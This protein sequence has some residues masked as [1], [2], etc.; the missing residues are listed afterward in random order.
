MVQKKIKKDVSN[1]DLAR[2]VATGFNTIEKKFEE[3]ISSLDEKLSGKISDLDEKLSGEING[4]SNRIDDLA[5]NRATL[6]AS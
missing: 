5:L 1:E 6:K 3:T 4:L 2:M